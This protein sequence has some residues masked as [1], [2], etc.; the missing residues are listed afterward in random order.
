MQVRREKV[1]V[2]PKSQWI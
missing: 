2:Q 1:Q